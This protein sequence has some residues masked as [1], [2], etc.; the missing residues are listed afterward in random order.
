MF[1][2]TSRIRRAGTIEWMSQEF[3]ILVEVTKK[4]PANQRGGVEESRN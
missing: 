4:V 1:V 2:F 3:P